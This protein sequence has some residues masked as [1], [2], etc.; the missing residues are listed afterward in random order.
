MDQSRST[1]M[2][3]LTSRSTQQEQLPDVAA[4]TIKTPMPHSYE[5]LRERH[6]PSS[7]SVQVASPLPKCRFFDF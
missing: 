7:L 2:K 4:A 1:P 3:P 5:P 6:V